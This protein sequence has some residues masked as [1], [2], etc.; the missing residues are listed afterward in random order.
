LIFLFSASVTFAGEAEVIAVDVKNEG[1][2]K[3][4][5]DVNVL[6][7]DEGW[8]H[9]VDKWDIV[10]LYGSVFGT[11]VLLHPHVNEQPFSRNLSSVKIPKTIRKVT[12][13][14]HCSIHEYGGKTVSVDI[15]KQD[16]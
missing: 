12:I 14:A 7:K 9:Y 13:R 2:N 11:R 15:L 3:Y 10:A 8:K 1:N 5:F 4:S 16:E 6:H